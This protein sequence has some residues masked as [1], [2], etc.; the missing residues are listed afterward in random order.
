MDWKNKYEG[1]KIN[2]IRVTER[3]AGGGRSGDDAQASGLGLW[4]DDGAISG[5]G[6]EGKSWF[7]RKVSLGPVVCE[8]QRGLPRG[9]SRWARGV[10]W[11]AQKWR[12][13]RRVSLTT[14]RNRTRSGFGVCIVGE[15]TY[16]GAQP[17]D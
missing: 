5:L 13:S 4:A 14:E 15:V 12:G 1:N 9:V 11:P 7:G 17:N 10:D 8:A 2:R 16:W 3:G 6:E